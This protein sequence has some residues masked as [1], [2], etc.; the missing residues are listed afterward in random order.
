MVDEN[1]KNLNFDL[2]KSPSGV[3]ILARLYNESDPMTI[4]EL[5]KTLCAASFDAMKSDEEFSE[6]IDIL[7]EKEWI[8]NSRRIISSQQKSPIKYG[9]KITTLGILAF[10]RFV[11]H[12]YY[13]AFEYDGELQFPSKIKDHMDS[14]FEDMD[15]LVNRLINAAI[16][17]APLIIEIT[18]ELIK[19]LKSM[20]VI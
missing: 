4:H 6:T 15:L 8:A 3:W 1:N 20:N 10:R 19:F 11:S 12:P 7:E 5:A 16:H 2:L 14:I 9:Y 13:K 18:T 17:N